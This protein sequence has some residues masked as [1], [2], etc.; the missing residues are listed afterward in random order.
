MVELKGN[1]TG[2]GLPAIV[3]LIGDLHHTGTLQLENK[4]AHGVLS[5]DG[6][7]LVDAQTDAASG[8]QAVAVCALDFADAEFTFVEGPAPTEPT[9]DMSTA[10]FKKLLD[11][12]TNGAY[13]ASEVPSN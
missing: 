9:L 5:F 2:I 8:L 1:L 7:R 3:Q 4:N 10:E 13:A 11:R 12:L 6:G